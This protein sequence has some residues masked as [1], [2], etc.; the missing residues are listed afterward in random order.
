LANLLFVSGLKEIRDLLVV[1]VEHADGKA[2]C[3]ARGA[4]HLGDATGDD[5]RHDAVRETSLRMRR[6]VV[7]LAVNGV[8]LARAS[9]TVR[10]NCDIVALEH[11]L[12]SRTANLVEHVCLGHVRVEDTVFKDK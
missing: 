8:G 12:G 9:L 6:L 1:D 10:E 4:L 5:F 11:G 7:T 3:D 2:V